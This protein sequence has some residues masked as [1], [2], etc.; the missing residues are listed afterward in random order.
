MKKAQLSI[1]IPNVFALGLFGGASLAIAKVVGFS[2]D[3]EGRSMFLFENFCEVTESGLPFSCGAL[4]T[5]LSFISVGITIHT[6]WKE[7]KKSKFQSLRIGNLQIS[8]W[9]FGVILYIFAFIISFIFM[10][11][12]LT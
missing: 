6:I 5:I 8:G 12:L 2:I 3:E 4:I 7:I 9:V 1:E 10:T 11:N